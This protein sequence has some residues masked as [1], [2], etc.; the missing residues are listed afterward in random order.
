MGCIV[1]ELMGM[2]IVVAMLHAIAAEASEVTELRVEHIDKRFVI[3]AN[4]VISAPLAQVRRVLTR[5][6]NLPKINPN[7]QTVKILER[8]APDQIRMQITSKTCILFFCKHYQWVQQAYLL[9]SGDILTHMDPTLSDFREGWVR[10]R[11][12]A[13]KQRT[14]LITDAHLAPNFWF[15]PVVGPAFIKDKLRGAALKTAVNLEK[16]AR[17]EHLADFSP[18]NADKLIR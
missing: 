10:Y 8:I 2:L 6:E 12:R 5:F 7:I 13:E 15:P 11:L 14:R 16:L 18:S 3:H 17:S 1:K 4:I 9:P